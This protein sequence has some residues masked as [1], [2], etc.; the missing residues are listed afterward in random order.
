MGLTEW[1]AKRRGGG[2]Q[3]SP[4]REG[5]GSRGP[6]FFPTFLHPARA[7]PAQRPPPI[8]FTVTLNFYQTA[9]PLPPRSGPGLSSF[10]PQM[11]ISYVRRCCPRHGDPAVTRP[12]RGHPTSGPECLPCQEPPPAPFLAAPRP[13]PTSPNFWRTLSLERVVWPCLTHCP[14]GSPVSPSVLPL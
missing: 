9:W 6:G 14:H 8:L 2:A 10:L 12:H 11:F 5:A 13:L 7:S 4:Q 1:G 3:H